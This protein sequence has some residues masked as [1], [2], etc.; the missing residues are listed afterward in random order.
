MARAATCR[1]RRVERL[2]RVIAE[3]HQ[4]VDGEV[5]QLQAVVEDEAVDLVAVRAVLEVERRVAVGSLAVARPHGAVVGHAHQVGGRLVDL[6][7]ECSLGRPVED[8]TSCIGDGIG[9]EY[10]FK[11]SSYGSLRVDVNILVKLDHLGIIP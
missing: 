11:L 8:S 1:E 2:E 9:H 6:T 4:V 3:L 10:S 7:D 5:V